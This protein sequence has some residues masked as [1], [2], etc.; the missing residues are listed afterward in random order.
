MSTSQPLKFPALPLSSPT[1]S[2]L[3]EGERARGTFKPDDMSVLLYGEKA[4]A[5]RVKA[6]S[7]IENNAVFDKSDVYFLSREDKMRKALHE[8]FEKARL[9][10]E[11]NLDYLD[12][13]A[14]DTL[15]E[16]SSPLTLNTAMFAPAIENLGT[17][18]QKAKYLRA[19]RNFEIIGCFAQTEL[20]HGSNVQGLETTATFIPES[21]EF[22]IHSPTLTAAKW[23]IG[24]LGVAC[25]HAVVMARLVLPGGKDYGPHPFVVRIRDQTTHKWMP[26]ITVGD[27]G[28]K[29]GFNAVDNGFVLFDRVRIPRSDMLARNAG[30]SR[31]GKYKPANAHAT[32]LNYGTMMFVRTNI[33]ALMAANV[34]KAATIAT[35]Y[36]A[37]RRQFAEKDASGAKG[38]AAAGP[39][40]EIQVLDYQSVQ[41]RILP[42]IALAYALSFT[43]DAM[44]RTYEQFMAELQTGEFRLL[45]ETHATSSGLKSLTTTLT[46]E[47]IEVC[48]RAMGGHGYSAFSGLAEF[49]ANVL[50]NATW[51]GDNWILTQQTARFLVKTL[52]ELRKAS[53]GLPPPKS[54]NDYRNLPTWYL[55]LYL[56]GKSRAAAAS[57]PI[58]RSKADLLDPRV[59]LHLL[60]LR[61]AHLVDRLAQRVSQPGARWN[62][63]LI[64]VARASNAHGHFAMVFNFIKAI[65]ALPQPLTDDEVGLSRH[66]GFEFSRPLRPVPDSLRA[67]LKQLSD[68]HALR[69][70]EDSLADLFEVPAAGFTA[71]HAEWVRTAL[72]EQLELVRPNAVALVDSF[73]LPD[74][75]LNSALGAYD[76]RVY[77]RMTEMA[78]REP[79][80]RDNGRLGREMML[81]D[82]IR[83]VMRSE[84]KWRDH[85]GMGSSKL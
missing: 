70:L 11:H 60:G 33:V 32:K 29:F 25:T 9:I 55:R 71:E 35:R 22:E 67:V 31:D 4:L 54:D 84:G 40:D 26:G 75:K 56:A 59:Q 5:T 6:L 38:T 80:N 44:V 79:L 2:E 68:L 42:A 7:L 1:T 85:P 78:G 19:A 34:A 28:P 14:I 66:S 51:E 37:V 16:S 69:V 43:G 63:A 77:E 48:R 24:G 62:D 21:D 30:V 61:S 52:A 74:F 39:A 17:E 12:H 57:A 46:M 83:R 50:P 82:E 76:G 18:E 23:W 49:Y 53:P 3:L 15:I 8:S 10:R 36:C 73:A 64:D 41:Y 13:S 72:R 47:T 20:K 27:V 58:V 81:D 45:A 65:G